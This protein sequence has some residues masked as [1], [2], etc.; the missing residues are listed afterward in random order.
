M[1]LLKKRWKGVESAIGSENAADYEAERENSGLFSAKDNTIQ[2]DRLRGIVHPLQL[3]FY[4]C[5]WTS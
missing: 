4:G 5:E 2:N 1:N 3:L